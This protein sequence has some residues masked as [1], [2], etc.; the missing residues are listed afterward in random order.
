MAW[1]SA[2]QE[3][4]GLLSPPQQ[5]WVS[6]RFPHPRPVRSFLIRLPPSLMTAGALNLAYCSDEAPQEL[7]PAPFF[8]EALHEQA[9][10]DNGSG[11]VLQA[12]T[13]LLTVQVWQPSH[14]CSPHVTKVV[15]ERQ[16][17]VSW[18]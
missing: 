15:S 8:L 7:L 13:T 5:A 17:H 4:L 6:W 3:S 12:E 9:P 14:A 2:A 18:A 16:A 1:G 10:H 11:R